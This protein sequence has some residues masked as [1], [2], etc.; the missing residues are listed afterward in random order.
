M[1]KNYKLACRTGRLKIRNYCQGQVM[2]AILL[3]GTFVM[4]LGLTISK[5]TIGEIR[6][7]T[8]EEMLKDAFNVAESGIDYFLKTE[9]GNYSPENIE[10]MAKVTRDTEVF[11]NTKALVYKNKI[12][13]NLDLEKFD[14]NSL[15]IQINRNAK[16]RLDLFWGN[17]RVERFLFDRQDGSDAISIS[18]GGKKYLKIMSID[19]KPCDF[20]II[21]SGGKF[22]QS[23]ITSI[24]YAKK[25]D[26]NGVKTVI[27]T[28]EEFN[29]PY[30][31]LDAV[32]AVG[33][34]S[35]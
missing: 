18:A 28:E 25:I 10:M 14:G 13:V 27:S 11:D 31:L 35:N 24:G 33:G 23:V 34:V 3:L 29:I 5:R 19:G 16:I 26:P 22:E 7:D 32:T 17:N 30:F 8:D 12:E 21:P 4:T 6:I 9:N 2:L 1:N 15:K 20:T